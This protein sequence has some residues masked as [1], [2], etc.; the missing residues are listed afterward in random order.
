MT[1]RGR[2]ARLKGIRFERAVAHWLETVTTRSQRP[3]IHDDAG[4]VVLDGFIVEC[5]DR[6]RW[7]LGAWW[8]ALL[9]KAAALEL[10]PVLIVKRPGKPIGESLVV[11]RLRTIE[12]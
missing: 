7:E 9:V 6:D 8:A 1:A 10:E 2:A 11:T 4:D 12:Q 3:G 5:R